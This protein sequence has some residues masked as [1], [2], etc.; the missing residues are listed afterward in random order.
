MPDFS[1]KPVCVALLCGFIDLLIVNIKHF[2]LWIV[3]NW[4]VYDLNQRN[5]LVTCSGAAL[6]LVDFSR[7]YP[8]GWYRKVRD[9]TNLQNSTLKVVH[10][11]GQGDQSRLMS[12]DWFNIEIETGY[13]I[14]KSFEFMFMS[15]KSVINQGLYIYLPTRACRTGYWEK[16]INRFNRLTHCTTILIAAEKNRQ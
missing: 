8:T 14:L 16:G 9:F 1:I 15:G 12:S 13:W 5:I 10:V 7:A 3:R 6:I 11:R 2:Q 4:H